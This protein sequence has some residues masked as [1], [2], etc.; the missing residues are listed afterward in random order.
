MTRRGQA[1]FTLIEIMAAIGILAV[2][3]SIMWGSF[4]QTVT[5]KKAIEAAQDRAHTVR[6][7][8][9]RMAR[10]IEESFLGDD[11]SSTVAERRTMFVGTA[12]GDVDELT[13][14]TFA[15]QRLRAGLNEG[16]TS[17]I[18]YYGER[19]PDDRRVLNLMRRET[20]RLQL[21]DPKQIPGESYLLCPDVAKVK[22]TYYDYKKKEWQSEWST[23]SASG[24]QYLPSHVRIS[25]T[26][27]DEHRREVT[28]ATD[29][30]IHLTDRVGYRIVPSN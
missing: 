30:R 21:E 28:Y 19:D 22:F 23:T 1:G 13:I 16:D 6:I 9:L 18:S 11:N 26:V 14:S 10:E 12:R 25:L 20:R 29:A 7:A 8:M 27:F 24:Y 4:T 3:T 17:V 15:H 5:R 2:V